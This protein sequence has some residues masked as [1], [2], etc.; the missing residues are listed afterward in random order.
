M[1]TAIE[2]LRNPRLVA[3]DLD[4][5]FGSGQDA[6]LQWD[7]AETNDALKLGLKLNA[8]AFSGNFILV[9]KDHIDKDTG[10]VVWSGDDPAAGGANEYLSLHHDRTNAVIV[11][12]AGALKLDPATDVIIA[13]NKGMV[14]G[15]TAQLTARFAYEL[16]VLGT[17]SAD[18]GILVAC[19]SATDVPRISFLRSRHT[20]IGSK[21]AIQDGDRMAEI[22]V[23]ADDGTDFNSVCADIVFEID[24]VP[25]ANDVPGRIM[26]RTTPNGAPSATERW[27]ITSAGVLQ[28]NGGQSISTSAGDL[29]LNPAGRV[30]L[31]SHDQEFGEIA[32]PA[33]PAA[34]S[35]RLYAKD[36]GSGKTQLV[37]RFPT[38]AVQVLATEP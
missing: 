35:A 7:T 16:Q 1:T 5:C 19:F 9:N 14:V 10:L 32:D 6:C 28:A 20:T 34:N 37:V 29:T 38:G 15:H 21:T 3:D 26:F 27:R 31:G 22:V 24:G 33:A 25:G 18:A 11:S 4:H 2:L 8:A 36:N 30:V 17:G 13:N 23:H 12:G